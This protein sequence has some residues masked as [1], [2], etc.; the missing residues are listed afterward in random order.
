[1][2]RLQIEKAT[3]GFFNRPA[4]LVAAEFAERWYI[5]GQKKSVAK[6]EKASI[7][8][9]IING[10]EAQFKINLVQAYSATN[11]GRVWKG[12]VLDQL[13]EMQP[14]ELIVY[15]RRVGLMP[16]IVTQGGDNIA[17]RAAEDLTSCT[18]LTNASQISRAWRLEANDRGKL[19]HL[20]GNR[21]NFE[22]RSA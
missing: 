20:G 3:F 1:M 8:S 18:Q 11:P 15:A 19:L 16:F 12:Q 4:E 14:G 9:L 2:E 21:F 22:K 17:L 10:V 7:V 13:K 5:E 6:P